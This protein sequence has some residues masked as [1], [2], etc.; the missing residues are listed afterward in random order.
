MTVYTW[1]GS[2]DGL[3][4][5]DANN[6]DANGKPANDAASVDT[7]NFPDG[8]TVDLV[9][10]DQSG[11][12]N[13]IGTIIP[14]GDLIITSTGTAYMKFAPNMQIQSPATANKECLLK[15]G[16]DLSN[17]LDL[18]HTVTFEIDPR[19]TAANCW[20]YQATDMDENKPLRVELYDGY[21][22][23]KRWCRVTAVT[24]VG[25]NTFTFTVDEIPPSLA[26]GKRC[27]FLR[28]HNRT[29]DCTVSSIDTGAKTITLNEDLSAEL[30]SQGFVDTIIQAG[31][32][33]VDVE[34]N[35]I[36][37]GPA[38]GAD[39]NGRIS[40][41]ISRSVFCC[42]I[43]GFSYGFQS[44]TA[45]H[46]HDTAFYGV[47]HNI[48]T[49]FWENGSQCTFAGTFVGGAK[50]LNSASGIGTQLL[51][52]VKGH[53]IGTDLDK[54]AFLNW[55]YLTPTVQTD[56][57]TTVP[58]AGNRSLAGTIALC[59]GIVQMRNL[60]ASPYDN[61]NML[62]DRGLERMYAG[63]IRVLNMIYQYDI[64]TSKRTFGTGYPDRI[65]ELDMRT[66]YPILKEVVDTPKAFMRVD[67]LT[68]VNARQTTYGDLRDVID[69]TNN[70]SKSGSQYVGVRVKDASI[71]LSA[72]GTPT[73]YEYWLEKGFEYGRVT[74]GVVG[75]PLAGIPAGMVNPA[76]YEFFS[77]T[78]DLFEEKEVYL[79]AGQQMTVTWDVHLIDQLGVPP[80]LYIVPW[81]WR[82]DIWVIDR[83]NVFNQQPYAGY[84]GSQ[85][86]NTTGV[87]QNFSYTFT[88]TRA[89][90]HQVG[91]HAFSLINT[92]QH[93]T[94][95]AWV[96]NFTATAAS[97]GGGGGDKVVRTVARTVDRTV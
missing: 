62:S 77:G 33:F 65:P 23:V 1:V 61:P 68:F 96:D 11:F 45:T 38:A 29:F 19:T 79:E 10:V 91:I 74:K 42:E 3:T 20:L 36:I 15:I 85:A 53:I 9:G 46:A 58:S 94:K 80:F 70:E 56:S 40:S 43:R 44:G 35:I 21:G 52:S 67:K 59:K 90:M 88:A 24:F 16:T 4:W 84:A 75:A 81:D 17:G 12:A 64:D 83:D 73:L 6:W 39:A 92:L 37:T 30:I 78:P 48:S 13:G 2:G 89:G 27:Q 50:A 26:V 7:I 71:L 34:S 87:T 63:R 25:G 76:K 60:G 72:T 82:S 57:S 54:S 93:A 18:A 49:V 86:A 5:E 14:A 55:S 69:L 47:A 66:A 51:I 41:G 22:W 97:S 95:T 32:F 8:V 31:V 28:D